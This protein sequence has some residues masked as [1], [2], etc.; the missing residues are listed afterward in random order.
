MTM[1]FFR[2]KQHKDE[3]LNAEIQ[4]HLGEAIRDRSARGE[5]IDRANSR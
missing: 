3:E 4:S 2:W 1:N 5:A